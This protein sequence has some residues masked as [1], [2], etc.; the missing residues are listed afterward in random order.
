MKGLVYLTYGYHAW[1]TLCTHLKTA[2]VPK[3]VRST[4]L[5][6]YS[7]STKLKVAWEKEKANY[8]KIWVENQAKIILLYLCQKEPL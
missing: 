3:E 5:A 4:F 2:H 7:G 6:K 8:E 1:H